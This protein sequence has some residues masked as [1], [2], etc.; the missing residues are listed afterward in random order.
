MWM[1]K[2][3]AQLLSVLVA[4][5]M[6]TLYGNSS[7]GGSVGNNTTTT[8]TTL[9]P[10]PVCLAHGPAAAALVLAQDQ[11]L[12]SHQDP[13]WI[14]SP[15]GYARM[16][17]T[18]SGD[19]TIWTNGGQ[20]LHWS[21]FTYS[22][23]PVYLKMQTDGNLVVRT[24]ADQS[25]VWTSETAGWD[26]TQLTVTDDGLGQI[27]IPH[28]NDDDDDD[29]DDLAATPVLWQSKG[30]GHWPARDAD[31][32]GGGDKGNGDNTSTTTSSARDAD[33]SGGSVNKVNGDGT[34]TTTTSVDT[35]TLYGKVLVGYLGWHDTYC[36][37]QWRGWSNKRRPGPQSYDFE[38]WPEM[39]EYYNG[40][41]ST[42]CPT[43]MR[44]SDGSVASLYSS[45]DWRTVDLHVKW[46]QD[47]DI[48]GLILE[49]FVGI[50]LCFRATVLRH[51]RS[52]AEKYGRAFA[53]QL[54]ISNTKESNV[55]DLVVEN[56]KF[57]VDHEQVTQSPQYL[58]HRGRPLLGLW[59]FGYTSRP[60][61]PDQV[62]RV[63]DWLQN[64]AEERYRVTLM[65]GVP[66]GWQNLTRNSKTDPSWAQVYRT[67]DVI[68]PWSVGRYQNAVEADA[69]RRD[70]TDPN[71]AELQQ[72]DDG[73][74]NGTMMTKDYLPVVFPGFSWSY[75]NIK[76]DENSY[77]FNQIPRDGG[78]FLWR[79]MYNGVDAFR[80]QS[81]S[82]KAA[83]Y[84]ATLD[85]V[86]E[87]TA[88]FKLGTSRQSVPTG[89]KFVTLDVDGYQDLPSDWYLQLVGAA[90][91]ALN[92]GDEP[93]PVDMPAIPRRHKR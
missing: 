58:H 48:D 6:D 30:C 79:Q 20:S 66:E 31:Q 13:H 27:T 50:S 60:G 63:L 28:Y 19:L 18:E 22:P 85:E 8:M 35:T 23:E 77:S 4:W 76:E 89:V 52:A 32:G 73:N 39:D 75:R 29:D 55:Y 93:F 81:S 86:N 65:G 9:Q 45:Y 7:G 49:Y 54:D 25:L 47:Y 42:L 88:I 38:L 44:Y 24:V 43:D 59:G 92:N 51:I 1:G 33:Q 11:L 90:R 40:D 37:G 53:V 34:S 41:G 57:L 5:L 15:N 67:Y 26:V 84:V 87:G 83:L 16:G 68:A 46:L 12:Y 82:S 61:T 71:L 10:D 70:Y 62:L 36:T 69:F 21:G 3:C 2:Q 72:Y 14:C 56:W 80:R 17:L 64:S 78:H 91:T 74:G